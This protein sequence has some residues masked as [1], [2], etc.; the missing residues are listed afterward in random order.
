MSKPSDLPSTPWLISHAL[1]QRMLHAASRTMQF[2][3]L[4]MMHVLQA[5][6]I[7]NGVEGIID[8]DFLVPIWTETGQRSG[9]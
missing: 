5:G 7:S 1:D 8:A 3:V 2:A 6:S 4:Q 9:S